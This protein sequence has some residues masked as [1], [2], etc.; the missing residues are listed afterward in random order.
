M[1]QI[2]ANSF[3]IR[4]KMLLHFVSTLSAVFV[5]VVAA[6]LFA[7]PARQP[8][9]NAA[10]QQATA[11]SGAATAT[12][13]AAACTVPSG[14]T[15]A[16]DGSAS[17]TS[18]FHSAAGPTSNSVNNSYATNIDSHD[19]NT[20]ILSN[21]E[22]NVLSNIANNN[23]INIPILNN[24]VNGNSILSDNPILSNNTVDAVVDIDLVGG[25]L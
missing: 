1:K 10:Q 13:G 18:A 3:G 19:E 23:N 6:L 2:N 22:T 17:I 8:L 12:Q 4:T 24:S 15:N 9:V 21:N 20:N 5:A 11:S 25:L 7:G 16:T 14:G